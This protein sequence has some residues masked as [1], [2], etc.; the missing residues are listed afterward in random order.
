MSL[1]STEILPDIS[2]GK[3]PRKVQRRGASRR[4]QIESSEEDEEDSA[5]DVPSSSESDYETDNESDS[6]D[7]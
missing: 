5:A 7:E 2:A 1:D 3:G 6:D 4:V